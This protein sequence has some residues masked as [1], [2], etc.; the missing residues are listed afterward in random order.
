MDKI[1]TEQSTPL[2]EPSLEDI[3]SEA[4][5]RKIFPNK[6]DMLTFISMS[7]VVAA[8][9]RQCVTASGQ[10]VYDLVYIRE[11]DCEK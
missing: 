6:A 4:N 5:K 9:F 7:N 11:D 2:I 1:E 10:L 3:F 8:Q